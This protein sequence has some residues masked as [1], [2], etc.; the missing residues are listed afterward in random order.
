[1]RAAEPTI[2][3]G[4]SVEVDDEARLALEEAEA[5]PAA[6]LTAEERKL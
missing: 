2:E 4:I 6:A 1:M 5:A 3:S